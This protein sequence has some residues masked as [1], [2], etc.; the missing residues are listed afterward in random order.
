MQNAARHHGKTGLWLVVV[1]LVLCFTPFQFV[2]GSHSLNMDTATATSSDPS[3]QKSVSLAAQKQHIVSLRLYLVRHGETLAN[4]QKIVVGQSDSPLTK[5][6]LH[7]ARELGQ[8][9]ALHKTLFWRRYSSDL[10]RAKHTSRLIDEHHTFELDERL[11][12]IA[13][14]ARQGFPKSYTLDQCMECFR[15]RPEE[16]PKQETSADAWKRVSRFLLGLFQEA[17]KEDNDKAGR[18]N[19]RKVLIVCHSGTIRLLLHKLV[20]HAHPLLEVSSDTTGALDDSKRFQIPNA[21]VTVL[22]MIIPQSFT[23]DLDEDTWV[24]L[25][26]PKV[27]RLNWIVSHDDR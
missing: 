13:K 6:G 24:K 11:R 18:R 21:S 19:I 23:S 4:I 25:V 10:E 17:L 22:D 8:S 12:E 7:Q 26:A 9:S 20:R 1:G 14:G 5:L 2:H 3:Y 16:I 15:E 27:V